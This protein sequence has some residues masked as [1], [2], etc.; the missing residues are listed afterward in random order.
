MIVD[1]DIQT[2]MLYSQFVQSELI[3]SHVYAVVIMETCILR[4][5]SLILHI[6]LV[7]T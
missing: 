6:D 5:T 7:Q 2:C 3:C 1:S 4:G